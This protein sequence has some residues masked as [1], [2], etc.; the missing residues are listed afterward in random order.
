MSANIGVQG[1][2]TVDV[3]HEDGSKD[4]YEFENLILNSGLD[5]MCIPT[6]GFFGRCVVGTSSVAPDA[7]QTALIAQVAS[8]S[9]VPE[10]TYIVETASSPRYNTNRRRYRFN[11]GTLNHNVAEIGIGPTTGNLWCRAL[12]LNSEGV[13]TAI[14]VTP[15][16][17]LD[18]TY[19]L[20]IYIPTTPVT[21][22]VNI[23]G[24]V[25]NFEL[26]P[27]R[28]NDADET[29]KNIWGQLLSQPEIWYQGTSTSATTIQA[30]AC[31]GATALAA[32]T[33][34][35]SLTSTPPLPPGGVNVVNVTDSSGDVTYSLQ[36]TYTNGTFT[37]LIR[38]AANLD[39]LNVTG[40][41][42]N[43][44]ACQ[45][46]AFPFQV[47]FSPAIP[48]TALKTMTLDFQFTFSRRT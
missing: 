18:V 1:F 37:R 12:T 13:P 44:L 14:T 36:G 10:S 24:T 15:T 6:A 27:L 4:T 30:S 26:A 47:L 32:Q 17:T 21:G 34:T 19:D 39:A 46:R 40:G 45:I 9:S 33:A 48:K 22:T 3:I 11:P 25:H 42:F 23:D 38:F 41:S 8:S 7:A 43:W 16:D 28:I 5:H 35:S 20:R 29:Y 2:F 31:T